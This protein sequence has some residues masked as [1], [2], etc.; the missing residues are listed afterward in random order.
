MRARL[1]ELGEGKR[2]GEITGAQ[3]KLLRSLLQEEEATE[4]YV[5][6]Q[7]I[8]YMKEEIYG[9]CYRAFREGELP[10]MTL[11]GLRGELGIDEE[12]AEQIENLVES[13]EIADDPERVSLVSENLE[14]AIGLVELL[15]QLVSERGE[16]NLAYEVVEEGK[17]FLIAGR[18]V[19]EEGEPLVGVRVSAFDRD[20]L[21]DDFLGYAFT[22]EEGRFEIRYAESDF[23]S[24]PLEKKPDLRLTFEVWNGEEF[25][26]VGELNLEREPEA[27]EDLG[28]IRLRR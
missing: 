26:R 9:C 2:L 25:E 21:V 8:T 19:N 6:D 15:E 11:R 28:E 23:K 17:P 1:Y 7:T 22:D 24:T 14:E 10:E 13:G 27:E 18:V 20:V 16:V 12:R 3:L 4:Y 5:D